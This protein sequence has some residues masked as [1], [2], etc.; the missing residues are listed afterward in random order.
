MRPMRVHHLNCATMCPFGGRLL[1]G[2]GSVLEPATLVC[3]CLLVETPDGLL[4]VDTGLGLGDVAD[5]SSRLG[6]PFV[7]LTRPR[8]DPAETAAQQIERLGFHRR[9][10]R[11]VA[12]T[13][14]D[15][16]HA[17]GLADFPEAT[18]HIYEPELDAALARASL[19]E[20]NR[21]RP[22]QW[23]HGPRWARYHT[24]GEA[25]HGFD[26]VRQLDGLPPEVLIVPLVG[27]TRGHAGIAVRGDG[28]WL[29]HAGDAYFFHGEVDVARPH[30]TPGL[31]LFQRAIAMDDRAR[32]GN[33]DRL[34]ALARDHAGDVQVFCAHDRLELERA[35]ARSR[36]DV[37]ATAAAP[38]E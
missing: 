17:G 37:L 8:L 3:H 28:G 4:L 15:L 35:R 32:R 11:H 26:C 24:R 13:H 30:C 2:E 10:V 1:S 6:G 38:A 20:K 25:W 33:R 5:A 23:A 21:Y 34:Q 12:L 9:D 14:L 27:H 19:P 36:E 22:V 29:L 7:A 16:D 31:A 18:V